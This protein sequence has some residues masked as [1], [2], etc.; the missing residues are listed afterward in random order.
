[1]ER[2]ERGVY[3]LGVAVLLVLAV[4]LVTSMLGLTN[5]V[6]KI[7]APP[8]TPVI[9]EH[10]T[11]AAETQKQVDEGVTNV[12]AQPNAKDSAGAAGSAGLDALCRMR[13]YQSDPNCALLGTGSEGMGTGD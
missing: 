12:N 4:W 11:R 1:M 2:V 5:R 7:V 6:E 10:Y 3:L 8:V 13:N 9:V